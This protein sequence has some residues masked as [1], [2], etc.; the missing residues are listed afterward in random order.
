LAAARA[1][2]GGLNHRTAVRR[3]NPSSL[4]LC[5]RGRRCVNVIGD[6]S[7]SRRSRSLLRWGFV[8]DHQ[9]TCPG[10][11]MFGY[12]CSSLFGVGRRCR[13]VAVDH[14]ARNAGR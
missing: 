7:V 12:V 6:S 5:G 11:G 3:V 13:V 9:S 14:Q 8:I 10:E 4:S 2:V 1:N